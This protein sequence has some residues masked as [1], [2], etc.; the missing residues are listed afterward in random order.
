MDLDPSSAVRLTGTKRAI[1][2]T[3]P[4]AKCSPTVGTLLHCV[5]NRLCF[6][7][8]LDVGDLLFIRPPEGP[9]RDDLLDPPLLRLLL[10][11]W[12]ECLH[13]LF[14]QQLQLVRAV[15]DSWIADPASALVVVAAKQAAESAKR[16]TVKSTLMT[17]VSHFALIVFNTRF[18]S[19]ASGAK[20]I[21]RRRRHRS[22][23]RQS[24]AA[25]TALDRR[26]MHQVDGRLMLGVRT[27]GSRR[28]NWITSPV[29][30][31]SANNVFGIVPGPFLAAPSNNWSPGS[32]G[33]SLLTVKI[34]VARKRGGII[35]QFLM[36]IVIA[37]TTNLSPVTTNWSTRNSTSSRAG[38]RMAE[39]SPNCVKV[40]HGCNS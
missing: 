36:V 23:C 28:S 24:T 26:R 33:S 13:D 38:F 31:G 9:R 35:G 6:Q 40:A 14:G 20:S 17:G 1:G 2:E 16:C 12:G 34:A 37:V 30:R 18:R 22:R 3:K 25:G 11:Q 5:G 15:N 29:E 8:G 7:E 19:G 4:S 32:F 27:R 39:E 10:G 21:P